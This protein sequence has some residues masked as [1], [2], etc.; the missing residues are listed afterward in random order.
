MA[1]DLEVTALEA[2]Q[3]H[4]QLLER[5]LPTSLDVDLPRLK[6]NV[7]RELQHHAAVAQHNGEVPGVDHLLEAKREVAVDARPHLRGR[8][9]ATELLEARA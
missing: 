2:S 5:R 8:L 7:V 6:E 9:G 4:R 1:G 3:D